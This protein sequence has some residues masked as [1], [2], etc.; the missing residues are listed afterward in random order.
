M[1][2][3]DRRA[4]CLVRGMKKPDPRAGGFLLSVLIIAGL[5]VGVAIGSP[6][7]GAVVGTA[8][9]IVAALLVW[10]ADR[11]RARP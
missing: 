9:G 1:P 11:G 8:T 3:A 10:V 6:I 4:L 7:T 2:L 5:V